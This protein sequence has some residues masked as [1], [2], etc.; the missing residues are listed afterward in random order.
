MAKIMEVMAILPRATVAKVCKLFSHSI[1]AV[2]EAG[3]DFFLIV[4]FSLYQCIT[5]VSLGKIY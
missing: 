4:W 1:K 2:V 3:D 5:S